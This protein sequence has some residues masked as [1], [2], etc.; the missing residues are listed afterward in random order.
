[1]TK[2][3][4]ADQKQQETNAKEN[5]SVYSLNDFV[6]AAN[7]FNV[8]KECIKAAFKAAN[9]TEATIMQAEKIINDFIK[10]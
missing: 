5:E 9:K 4:T 1:M 8:S 6:L 3:K 7:R 2:A 10:K